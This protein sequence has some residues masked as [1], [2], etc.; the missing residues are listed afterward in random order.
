MIV[1]GAFGREFQPTK[2]QVKNGRQWQCE[3]R[4]STINSILNEHKHRLADS[5]NK[6]K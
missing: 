1:S 4:N 2:T 3:T 5:K 6:K